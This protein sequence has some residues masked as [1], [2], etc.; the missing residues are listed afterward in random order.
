VNE[1]VLMVKSVEIPD[2]PSNLHCWAKLVWT[3]GFQEEQADF[4]FLDRKTA[5]GWKRLLANPPDFGL[6]DAS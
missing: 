6:V 3:N 2:D 1:P 5:E 4:I